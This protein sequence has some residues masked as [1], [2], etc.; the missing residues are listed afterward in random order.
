MPAPTFGH[1]DAPNALVGNYRTKDGRHITL[2]MLQMDRFWS[3]AMTAIG[4]PE[5]I[6]DPRFAD[7][8]TRFENRVELIAL[9]DEAF[10]KQ[11]LEQWRAALS[12]LSGA[13]GVVQTPG[14]LCEDPATVAN[15]YVAQTTTMSGATFHLSTNPVQFDERAVVPSGAPEHGQHTEEVL[16][17]AGLDWDTIE[18]YK[19]D[20][21]VL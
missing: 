1:S 16:M 21:A 12:D 2:M 15:G 8:A 4:L 11:T 6:A 7:P 14:E 3:E 17:D 18:K 9:M 10:G 5:L 19:T 20:G 13:W